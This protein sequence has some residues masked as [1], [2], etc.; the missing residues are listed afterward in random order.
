MKTNIEQSAMLIFIKKYIGLLGEYDLED[1]FMKLFAKAFNKETGLY[2]EDKGKFPYVTIFKKVRDYG[3]NEAWSINFSLSVPDNIEVL[4]KLLK[5]RGVSW[6]EFIVYYH[7]NDLVSSYHFR[8]SAP[9]KFSYSRNGNSAF[10]Y[11]LRWLV[12]GKYDENY[13]QANDFLKEKGISYNQGNFEFE[14]GNIKVKS[15]MNGRLDIN[16]L[17][18]DQEKKTDR[19]LE[20]HKAVTLS[21]Y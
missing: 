2:V 7:T 3:T 18:P 13:E 5:E 20:I 6:T 14:I 11:F 15:F 19:Y 12:N 16:G 17:T 8:K 21:P 4:K 10:V 9:K 1:L